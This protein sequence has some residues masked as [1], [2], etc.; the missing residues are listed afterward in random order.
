M[1]RRT[2]ARLLLFTACD[3]ECSYCCNK[4]QKM[5]SELQEIDSVVGLHQYD[6]MIITGGEPLLDP[7]LVVAVS[8]ILRHIHPTMKMY[9]YTARCDAQ[10]VQRVLPHVDGIHFTIH[11]NANFADLGR[12]HEL[13]SRVLNGRS[14]P[15]WPDHSFRLYIH[16]NNRH[17]VMVLPHLWH[18]LEIKPWVSE[19]DCRTP[20]EM[21]EDLFILSKKA[22]KEAR[23]ALV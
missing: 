15:A 10:A 20:S 22:I 21:G 12:F 7:D 18:R 6:E 4:S 17:S 11:A 19:D 1:S 8:R 3:R 9:L 13:Q 23:N 2:K 14:G 5:L 16:Q